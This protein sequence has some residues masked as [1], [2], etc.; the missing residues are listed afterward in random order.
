MD[1]AKREY[2]VGHALDDEG[3]GDMDG[4]VRELAKL[5]DPLTGQPLAPELSHA[6][7]MRDQGSTAVLSA[8]TGEGP[9][10]Y[11]KRGIPGKA[12]GFRM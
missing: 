1:F 8:S 10:P 3:Y 11:P 9:K 6:S 7:P 12:G 4:L 5:P 2:I